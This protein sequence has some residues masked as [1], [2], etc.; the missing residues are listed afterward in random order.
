MSGL[1]PDGVTGNEPQIAGLPVLDVE[2]ECESQTY[3]VVPTHR[4]MTELDLAL[5]RLDAFA[6]TNAAV[7]ALDEDFMDILA[8][9]VAL[10]EDIRDRSME[11]DELPA[12]DWL[13]EEEVEVMHGEFEIQCSRCGTRHVCQTD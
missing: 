8:S 4:V 2:R 6:K 12:C 13:M 1:Y 9:L 11:V 3:E 7:A 5:H 10:R